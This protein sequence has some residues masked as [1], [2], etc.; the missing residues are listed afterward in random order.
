MKDATK[1]QRAK[2]EDLPGMEQKELPLIEQLASDYYETD[3]ERRELTVLAVS[4]R[5]ALEKAMEQEGVPVYRFRD[6]VVKIN[7]TKKASVRR[8]SDEDSEEVEAEASKR[9]TQEIIEDLKATAETPAEPSAEES[10]SNVKS[11]LKGKQK[12]EAAKDQTSDE[13]KASAFDPKAANDKGLSYE[14]YY[15]WATG[16]EQKNPASVAKMAQNKRDRDEEVMDW[17]FKQANGSTPSELFND[18]AMV[19]AEDLIP[20]NPK[21]RALYLALHLQPESAS[22]WAARRTERPSNLSDEALTQAIRLE[23]GIDE[24]STHAQSGVSF[25]VDGNKVPKFWFG[26]K[27]NAKQQPTLQGARLL[28]E[29]RRVLQLPTPKRASV[30]VAEAKPTPVARK[31][32]GVVTKG[33]AR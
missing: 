6:L 4:K 14:D 20:T 5:Q 33:G 19:V 24:Q 17:L 11:F 21:E 13:A 22:R 29:T 26:T 23:F 18:V 1:R 3:A 25:A 16:T 31:G 2:Q 27:T 7:V 30:K 15:R 12:A 10:A 8:A 32:A 28:A 9:E